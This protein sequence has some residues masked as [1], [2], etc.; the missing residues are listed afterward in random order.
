M[1][2]DYISLQP[3]DR[4]DPMSRVFPRVTKCTFRK[5]GPSGT[6]QRHDAQVIIFTYV[7][8]KSSVYDKQMLNFSACFPST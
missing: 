4:I 1:N 7:I 5:F 6:I 3:R 2:L 8:L